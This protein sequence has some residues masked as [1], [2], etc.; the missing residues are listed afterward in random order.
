MEKL[1]SNEVDKLISMLR[2]GK[3]RYEIMRE[4]EVP[5]HVRRL[6]PPDRIAEYQKAC[7]IGRAKRYRRKLLRFS[8]VKCPKCGAFLTNADKNNGD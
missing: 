6:I 2:E 4:L 5:Y 8:M 7:Q 1:S 3:T